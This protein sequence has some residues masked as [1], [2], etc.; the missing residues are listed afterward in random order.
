MPLSL[1]NV[2]YLNEGARNVNLSTH[3]EISY[4]EIAVIT[5]LNNSHSSY[6]ARDI[7]AQTVK[8]SCTNP[9]PHYTEATTRCR[10]LPNISEFSL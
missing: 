9:G 7:L 5:C 6:L 3:T 1:R 4:T 2:A 8:P 10:V